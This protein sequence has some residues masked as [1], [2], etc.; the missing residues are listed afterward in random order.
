[1]SLHDSLANARYFSLATFRRS[2]AMVATPVWFAEDEEVYYVFSAGDA[3]KVKRLR[4]GDTAQVAP[5]DVRGVV[6]GDW[7]TAKATLLADGAEI[8]HALKV[9]RRKYGWL[10]RMTDF[11]SQ[12]SGRFEKRA[13][14]RVEI[15]EPSE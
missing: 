6:S 9:L 7:L 10:M 1:M 8:Q 5:C 13:Y 4:L 12:L 2:G 14:I 11:F 15:H 3:G